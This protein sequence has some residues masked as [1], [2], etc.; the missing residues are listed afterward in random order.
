II[1]NTML[2]N[3]YRAIVLNGDAQNVLIQG[4][5]MLNNGFGHPQNIGNA[6]VIR[7]INGDPI[8]LGPNKD[9]TIRQNN[10]V[11]NKSGVW[12]RAG[13]ITGFLQMDAN[14]IFDNEDFGFNNEEASLVADVQNNWWGCNAGTLDL[15]GGCDLVQGSADANPWVLLRLIPD[16]TNIFTGGSVGLQSDLTQNADGQTLPH[17]LVDNI[18]TSFA[19]NLGDVSPSST[20][21]NAGIAHSNF[22]APAATGTA[23]LSTTVDNQTIS[24]DI[25]FQNPITP[26]PPGPPALSLQGSGSSCSF[27]E[28]VFF[29]SGSSFSA[30]AFL[31]IL[32]IHIKM[33][34]RR[35]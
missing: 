15:A 25:N 35:K 11:G 18:P 20:I 3:I 21:A 5:Q 14:R 1:H 16:A 28:A 22:T 30:W 9:I 23:T 33:R 12:A 4:N 8:P 6:I 7:D 17:P 19:T 26:P 2:N 32:L 27:N 13:G 34:V 31:S 24:L 29:S 10:I